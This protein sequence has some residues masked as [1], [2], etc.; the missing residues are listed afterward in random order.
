MSLATG[1]NIGAKLEST[2]GLSCFL[3]VF[4]FNKEAFCQTRQYLF[5]SDFFLFL[6]C[7]SH[8]EP[9][10]TDRASPPTE[11]TQFSK[12]SLVTVSRNHASQTPN[13]FAPQ[14]TETFLLIVW[15]FNVTH[16]SKKE[17]ESHF[18]TL[19]CVSPVER[20]DLEV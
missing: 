5:N 8:Q 9:D 1:E 15:Q 12:P 4:K 19:L 11:H 16:T 17:S 18:N 2:P 3:P 6:L 7:P 13:G 14:D 20:K 10:V